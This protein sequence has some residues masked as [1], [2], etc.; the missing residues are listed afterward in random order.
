MWPEFEKEDL[1]N[2]IEEFA[3]RKRNFGK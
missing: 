1:K 3:K 2:I